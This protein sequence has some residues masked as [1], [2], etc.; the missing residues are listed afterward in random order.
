MAMMASA[1]LL[2]QKS[3]ATHTLPLEKNLFNRKQKRMLRLEPS[4][5]F[6]YHEISV[7]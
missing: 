2:T 1:G 5:L 7:I 4:I 3:I 6:V